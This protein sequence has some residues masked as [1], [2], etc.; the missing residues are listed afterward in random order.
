MSIFRV[1]SLLPLLIAV[2]SIYLLEFLEP[3]VPRE[4]ILVRVHALQPQICQR[5]LLFQHEFLSL[6]AQGAEGATSLFGPVRQNI[7]I[8]DVLSPKN[9]FTKLLLLHMQIV[10]GARGSLHTAYHV[11]LLIYFIL[12]N[13]YLIKFL[14]S[15]NAMAHILF[16]GLGLERVGR[17]DAEIG[18]I[19]VGW[20]LFAILVVR[21][22]AFRAQDTR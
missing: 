3:P 22:V 11:L 16:F 1:E 8:V 12:I 2:E 7:F 17:S 21:F 13:H 9:V 5:L 10:G 14:L 20:P 19:W 6:A 4:L 15:L 18:R